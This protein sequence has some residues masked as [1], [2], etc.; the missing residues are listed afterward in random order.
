MLVFEYMES[1]LSQVLK[2]ITKPLSESQTKAY[3]IMLLQG[4]A[5]CHENKIMHRDLK[6]ANLLISSSRVLKVLLG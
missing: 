2:R 3:L 4:L 1:D 5:F 6:P